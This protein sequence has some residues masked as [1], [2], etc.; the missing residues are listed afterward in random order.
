MTNKPKA[1]EDA[2][3]QRLREK[4][5]DLRVKLSLAFDSQQTEHHVLVDLKTQIDVLNQKIITRM[6]KLGT[7]SNP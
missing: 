2:E 7:T 5:D 4:V 1:S 3:I 6:R